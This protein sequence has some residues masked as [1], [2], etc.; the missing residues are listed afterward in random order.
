MS[1]ETLLEARGTSYLLRPGET[2]LW[3]RGL[4][5]QAEAASGEL[6]LASIDIDAAWPL[7]QAPAEG[8]ALAALA[9]ALHAWP[10]EGLQEL[11]F[12]DG[13]ASLLNAVDKLLSVAEMHEARDGRHA[14]AKEEG[15]AALVERPSL[16]TFGALGLIDPILRHLALLACGMNALDGMADPSAGERTDTHT[17]APGY[18]TSSSLQG[19]EAACEFIRARLQ[20]PITLDDLEAA[21][22]LSRRSLQYAF[23]RRFR[24]TP[25]QWVR[26]QRLALTRRMLVEGGSGESVTSVGMQCGFANLGTFARHYQKRFGEYPSETLRQAERARLA[27]ASLAA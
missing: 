6:L 12:R 13:P 25:M 23:W 27:S 17:A 4:P 21:S 15:A 22:G 26:E 1:G 9:G 5:W 16:E 18:V 24:L 7:A 20:A 14:R 10:E 2:A 3:L 19:L 11:E 8:S